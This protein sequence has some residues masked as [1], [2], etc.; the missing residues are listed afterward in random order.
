MTASSAQTAARLALGL[1]L[2]T[3]AIFFLNVLFGGPLG[4][5]PWMSDVGEM[6][7]L[8]LAVIFFVLGAIARESQA[9]LAADTAEKD[10]TGSSET[11]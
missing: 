1:S 2:L 8:F 10:G 3:F 4:R 11:P 9:R 6:L 7:T 5:K